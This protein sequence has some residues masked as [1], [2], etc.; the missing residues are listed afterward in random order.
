MNIK[1]F[2]SM[3][4]IL[5]TFV[6]FIPYIISILQGKTKPHMFS[7]VI[8]GSTTMVVFFAQLEDQGGMGA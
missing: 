5:I 2:F 1:F 7:W 4:A 6:A 3:T 8:W